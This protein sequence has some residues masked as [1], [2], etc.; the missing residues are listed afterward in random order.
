MT[1]NAV[2]KARCTTHINRKVTQSIFRAFDFAAALGQP[3]NRLI[4]IHLNETEKAASTTIFEKIRHKYR[5]WLTYKNKK[6]SA[7]IEPMYVYTFENPRNE[8]PH[9]NWAV[10]IPDELIEEF[11]KKLPGWVEKVQ[12]PIT[13]HTIWQDAIPA[14]H[15]KRIAKYMAKGTDP[16]Y[17][18]HFYLEELHE[19]HGPQGTVWGK[20]AGVSPALGESAR[21]AV[22]FRPRR[23]RYDRYQLVEIGHHTAAA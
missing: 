23:R 13:P 9:V 15:A 2:G 20:R 18:G 3:L 17:L 1:K 4:V 10:H 12:G 16:I 22:G 7:R 6:T 11:S 19:Q 14:S 5:D 21:R 8:C